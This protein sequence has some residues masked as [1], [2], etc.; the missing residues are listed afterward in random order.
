[1]ESTARDSDTV[2]SLKEPV[3]P[4]HKEK[5]RKSLFA[6]RSRKEYRLAD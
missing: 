4:F 1:M 6:T 3:D 2:L 5:K